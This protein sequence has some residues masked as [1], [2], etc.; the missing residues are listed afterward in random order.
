MVRKKNAKANYARSG[1]KPTAEKVR[2]TNQAV[3]ES[4]YKRDE[5][6]YS[7]VFHDINDS[8]W[9]PRIPC[10]VD[11]VDAKAEGF[12]NIMLA[13][14]IDEQMVFVFMEGV[15]YIPSAGYNLFSPGLA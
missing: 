7:T 10:F 1:G 5:N 13:S 6:N 4:A 12:G 3:S 8:D 14:M 2:N 9:N 11:G 15:L